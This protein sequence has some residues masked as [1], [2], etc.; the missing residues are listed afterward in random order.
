MSQGARGDPARLYFMTRETAKAWLPILQAYAEGKE[1]QNLS[2]DE[3]AWQ[4]INVP[5]FNCEPSD[6]RIK[7]TPKLRPWKPEEVP[8]D[9]WIRAQE[10]YRDAEYRWR[11]VAVFSDGVHLGGGG[12][13]ITFASLLERYECSRVNAYWLPCGILEDA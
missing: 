8:S 12:M 13:A 10:R 9:L 7:P 1:I 4:T 11:I 2:C 6:Y 5:F 3:K